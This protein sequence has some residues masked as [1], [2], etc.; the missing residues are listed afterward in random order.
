[1][2]PN[3]IIDYELSKGRSSAEVV[4]RL[5]LTDAPASLRERQDVLFDICNS[6]SKFFSIPIYLVRVAGSAQTGYSF[7]NARDF[8]PGSSDCDVAVI[9][10]V[11]FEKY[12][13]AVQAVAL[14]NPD[15]LEKPN[16]HVF[17][18]KQGNSHFHDFT[19][20]V[21]F[22]GVLMPYQMPACPEKTRAKPDDWK[23]IRAIC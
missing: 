18:G 23:N 2:Q 20:N 22:H 4:R 10:E 16:R 5:Y 11:V 9:S 3:P 13:R 7:H 17:P 19:M 14:P 6:I 12:L 21:A 8:S 1:M 15:T